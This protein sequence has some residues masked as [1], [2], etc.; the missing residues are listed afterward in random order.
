MNNKDLNTLLMS[1]IFIVDD[2]EHEIEYLSSLLPLHFVRVIKNDEGEFLLS[3]AQ[4]AIKEAYIATNETKYLLLA[5]S[6]FNLVAQNSLLK[7]IEEPPKNIVIIMITN[8]KSTILPT[9]LSR[10]PYQIKKGQKQKNEFNFELKSISLASLYA[11][12][13]DNANINKQTAKEFVEFLLE[14]AYKNRFELNQKELDSFYKAIRLIELNSKPIYI[15][16][17]LLLML[18]QKKQK[19]SYAVL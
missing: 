8:S 10:M 16:T 15:I 4:L 13:Q 14:S 12:V 2:I 19:S 18:L 11:F 1:Q 7:L 3:Q 17:T 6:T 5:G 9:I